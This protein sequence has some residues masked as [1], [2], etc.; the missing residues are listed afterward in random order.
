MRDSTICSFTKTTKRRRSLSENDR[1]AHCRISRDGLAT[2]RLRAESGS[3]HVVCALRRASGR[4][5]RR[6]S[7]CV[8]GRRPPGSESKSPRPGSSV[9][10]SEHSAINRHFSLLTPTGSQH[11][12]STEVMRPPRPSRDLVDRIGEPRRIRFPG[13]RLQP[14]G[15]LSI[16]NQQATAATS[17]GRSRN[18]VRPPDVPRSLTGTWTHCRR[19]WA[20]GNARC[21]EYADARPACPAPMT[22]VS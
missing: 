8:F 20:S 7:S 11:D 17:G 2:R 21:R 4:G 14:L 22:M 6:A 18:C 1:K 13:V 16:L 5:R 9:A 12:R 10:P 15:H 19:G 3:G